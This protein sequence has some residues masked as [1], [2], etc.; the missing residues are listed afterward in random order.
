ML[1]FEIAL[2]FDPTR[3]MS[4]ATVLE[5]AI[6]L[7]ARLGEAGSREL[8]LLLHKAQIVSVAFSAEQ[9]EVARYA[10]RMYG[11]G[12]HPAGLNYGDCSLTPWQKRLG[13]PSSLKATISH[14]LMSCSGSLPPSSV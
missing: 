12:R 4:T 2:E 3:L 13:R 8:D 7:E 1:R 5:T 11:K 6:V 14:R 10:F 9:V